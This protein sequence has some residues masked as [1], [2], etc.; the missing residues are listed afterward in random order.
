MSW[1]GSQHQMMAWAHHETD[2]ASHLT[3]RPMH[4]AAPLSHELTD[5]TKQ[6]KDPL[7][8][9]ECSNPSSCAETCYRWK[10]GTY[11]KKV[12]SIAFESYLCAS[13]QHIGQVIGATAKQSWSR[14]CKW[15][16]ES[17]CF[18]LITSPYYIERRTTLNPATSLISFLQILR[19]H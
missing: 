4:F 1:E 8:H 2:Y 10:I 13:A 5:V 14:R 9:M 11:E 12:I 17:N 19:F 16:Y 6:E 15:H 7:A 3:G 18:T